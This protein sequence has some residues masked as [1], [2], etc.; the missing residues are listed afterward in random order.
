MKRLP[1]VSVAF[2]AALL[3]FPGRAADKDAPGG[4]SVDKDK[5]FQTMQ[6]LRLALEKYR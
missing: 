6:E 5:R 4:V 2:C 3:A 1:L